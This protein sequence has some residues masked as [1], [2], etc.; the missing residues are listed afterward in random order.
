MTKPYQVIAA[1]IGMTLIIQGCGSAIQTASPL[2]QASATPSQAS[3]PGEALQLTAPASLEAGPEAA[4][5]ALG[6]P[7]Q[8]EKGVWLLL[9]GLGIGVYTGDG[10]QI[11]AGSETKPEDFWI[12][13]FE[14]P[15]LVRLVKESP[16][17]FSEFQPQLYNLGL[18]ASQEEMLKRMPRGYADDHPA[19][20]W[21]RYQSFTVGRA[22][23]DDQVT[24]PRLAQVLEKDFRAMLPLVRWLNTALGLR[25]AAAR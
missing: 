15:L 14:V 24:G 8:V 19:A 5:A 23:K 17:P 21:L 6:D 12:Y 18:E 3:G 22:L 25:A 7:D 20:P 2:A 4:A 16:R 9:R 10:K 1:I 11:L 13:D